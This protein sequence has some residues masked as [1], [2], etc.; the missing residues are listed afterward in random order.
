MWQIIWIS[1][2]IHL[3]SANNIY[4]FLN[5]YQI[6]FS[7]KPHLHIDGREYNIVRTKREKIN[8]HR[9]FQIDNKHNLWEPTTT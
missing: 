9:L 6:V 7:N 5:V 8:K 4:I 2:G 1:D 3:L